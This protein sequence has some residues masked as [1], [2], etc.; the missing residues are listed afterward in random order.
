MDEG[1]TCRDLHPSAAINVTV[2][3]TPA[4]AVLYNFSY[5]GLFNGKP[6][7]VGSHNAASHHTISTTA[8][9]AVSRQ[10][11]CPLSPARAPG[12]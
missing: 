4:T 3:A 2:R 9:T 1:C 6:Y 7:E 8:F 10:H 5:A 12:R 11:V